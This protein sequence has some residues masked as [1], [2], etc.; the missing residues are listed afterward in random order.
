MEGCAKNKDYICPN[1]NQVLK[2][3]ISCTNV[4]QRV[5]KKKKQKSLLEHESDWH[6]NVHVHQSVPV[7]L[8]HSSAGDALLTWTS[9]HLSLK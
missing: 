2:Q 6:G 4:F 5:K 3:M 8:R 9:N 1:C 7:Y